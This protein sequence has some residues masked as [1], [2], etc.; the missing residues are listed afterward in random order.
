MHVVQRKR[1]QQFFRNFEA[2]VS[3]F[4]ENRREMSPSYL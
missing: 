2:S 4:P 1:F 3:K